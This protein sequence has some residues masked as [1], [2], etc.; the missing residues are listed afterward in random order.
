MIALRPF[1]RLVRLF[2]RLIR[3]LPRTEHLVPT[4]APARVIE[5]RAQGN[6]AIDGLQIDRRSPAIQSAFE[7][8]FTLVRNLERQT[9]EVDPAIDP[10][11]ADC[12]F[13][14]LR[15]RHVHAAV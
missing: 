9:G 7:P 2:S 1:S 11:R 6:P 14:R 8:S 10:D 5:A 3:L 13:C 12:G 4:F 15:K